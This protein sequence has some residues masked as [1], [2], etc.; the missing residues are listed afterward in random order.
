[1][2]MLDNIWIGE[3]GPR[4]PCTAL[5][6]L[7]ALASFPLDRPPWRLSG[8]KLWA[9]LHGSNSYWSYYRY[10]FF[11][12]L[13]DQEKGGTSDELVGLR[14]LLEAL[15]KEQHAKGA[16]ARYTLV[17]KQWMDHPSRKLSWFGWLRELLLLR[18]C[19]QLGAKDGCPDI[20][21]SMVFPFAYAASGGADPFGTTEK[22]DHWA[23]FIPPGL[24]RWEVKASPYT[25]LPPGFDPKRWT[26]GGRTLT[27][28][29]V[30]NFD[31]NEPAYQQ[32]GLKD[33]AG[34]LVPDS[35]TILNS[36]PMTITLPRNVQFHLAGS[37]LD[38]RD[39]LPKTKTVSK[40][41]WTITRA[42]ACA[43]DLELEAY[44]YANTFSLVSKSEPLKFLKRSTGATLVFEVTPPGGKDAG[45]RTAWVYLLSGNSSWTKD[46]ANPK[47]DCTIKIAIKGLP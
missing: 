26:A 22:V 37:R 8:S 20:P 3:V 44:K 18:A 41:Q 21:K 7:S 34:V 45:A 43:A 15:Q 28:A 42:P 47:V 40:Y 12:Y 29:K 10:F 2:G 46:A 24:K 33:G 17:V 39:N 19:S 4:R 36:G 13:F 14:T 31:T 11:K 25:K 6:L 32:T 27:D 35:M 16:A 1:M 23:S 9:A 30:C 5:V 38:I